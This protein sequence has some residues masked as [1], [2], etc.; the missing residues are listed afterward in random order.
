MKISN[1]ILWNISFKDAKNSDQ[2][3]GI[4]TILKN[5]FILEILLTSELSFNETLNNLYF[6]GLD[7]ERLGSC[8]GDL[9]FG[10]WHMI[11]HQSYDIGL[12]LLWF[13]SLQ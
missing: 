12:L 7:S 6:P 4:N 1:F 10:N 11:T 9:Y 2:N 3:A 5:D 13:L 8:S